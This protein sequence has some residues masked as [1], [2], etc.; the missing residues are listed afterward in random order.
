MKIKTVLLCVLCDVIILLERKMVKSSVIQNGVNQHTYAR[1]LIKR[2][3]WQTGCHSTEGLVSPSVKTET[4]IN[5]RLCNNKSRDI[6]W[7]C[8]SIP[9]SSDRGNWVSYLNVEFR[10]LLHSAINSAMIGTGTCIEDWCTSPHSLHLKISTV[11][12]SN[13][14]MFV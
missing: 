3:V 5:K 6:T 14:H 10:C 1:T 12:I 2:T 7:L 4:V 9:E 8:T 13:H 11:A